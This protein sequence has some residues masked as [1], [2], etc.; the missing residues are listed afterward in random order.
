VDD[1]SEDD[2]ASVIANYKDNRLRYFYKN[3][4]ERSAARNFGISKANGRFICFLDSD[5]EYLSGF[6]QQ[7]YDAIQ[8]NPDF[9]IFRSGTVMLK[10]GE[11]VRLP[12]GGDKVLT[13]KDICI[14]MNGLPSYC[15]HVSLFGKNNFDR[16][17][18]IG[19][20]FHFLSGIVK[21]HDIIAVQYYGFKFNFNEKN[22]L[23]KNL[24]VVAAKNKL[25]CYSDLLLCEF[26]EEQQSLIFKNF[27]SVFN[28]SVYIFLRTLNFQLAG[29]VLKATRLFISKRRAAKG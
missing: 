8:K 28:V 24:N 27:R 2:S 13:F 15:F 22:V 18:F 1:G 29:E 17:F 10:G 16:R 23:T 3:H 26:T 21:N 25:Q 7:N 20:D 6:L 19:E 9:L 12:L 14:N 11:E 4:E 5:D